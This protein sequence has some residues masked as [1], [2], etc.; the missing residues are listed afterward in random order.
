MK[1]VEEIRE[2]EQMDDSKFGVLL[3]GAPGTGKTTFSKSMHSFFDETVDRKHCMVNLDPANENLVFED[4]ENGPANTIDV[5]DLITLEDAME[6]FKLGPNGA[7]LYCIEFLL[8]NF[9]W[10]SDKMNTILLTKKC[11]YFVIDMPG[12]VELYTNHQALKQIISRLQNEVGLR[13]VVVHMVDISYVYDRYRFLSAL[14]LSLTALIN[15]EVPFLNFITKVDLLGQM[16]RPD[17]NLMFYHGTTYGLKY[18][19]FGEYTEAEQKIVK[20]NFNYRYS[21][22]TKSLCELLENYQ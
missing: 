11:S 13:L 5:R 16:G 18:L 2:L 12:Q 3:L 10:L 7:M 20:K 4:G 22:L 6:E 1:S 8:K 19:F 9:Q 14:T 21:R 17:M 15:L